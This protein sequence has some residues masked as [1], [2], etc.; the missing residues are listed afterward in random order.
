[1]K[2]TPSQIRIAIASVVILGTI[3]YLAVTGAEATKSYYVTVAEMQGMGEKA[4]KTNLRVEGYVKPQT[5]QQSGANVT[6][7]LTE[8]ESHNPK[9][10]P[11]ARAIRVDYRGSEP[12]PDTFKGDA[13]A[14]AIGT[15]GRDGGLSCDGAPG[16]V[17]QQVCASGSGQYT[18]LGE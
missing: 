8:F 10:T 4:Y 12:P 13:Q 7:V 17:R 15:W 1:M 2:F 3:G 6:F 5:I 14:L 16:Q 11:S 9:A 18:G